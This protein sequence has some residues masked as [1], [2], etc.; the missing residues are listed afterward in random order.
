[1]LYSFIASS[2]K[3]ASIFNFFKFNYDYH[4][5]KVLLKTQYLGLSDLDDILFETGTINTSK[6]RLMFKEKNFMGLS[7]NMREA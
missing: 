4:N 1:M 2:V 5:I 3:D 7:P 6:L